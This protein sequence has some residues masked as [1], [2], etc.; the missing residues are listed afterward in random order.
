MENSRSHSWR[1]RLVKPM[2][3]LPTRKA[4]GTAASSSSSAVA[5]P[6]IAALEGGL[7][8]ID[9]I[10]EG[11]DLEVVALTLLQNSRRE[12]EAALHG[13]QLRL[14]LQLGLAGVV[15]EVVDADEVAGGRADRGQAP[16]Q[17]RRE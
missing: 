10:D 11:A 9:R 4:A 1:A 5:A 7:F 15:D 12:G 2:C 8:H 14:A 13:E 16:G 17:Q 6:R 3:S